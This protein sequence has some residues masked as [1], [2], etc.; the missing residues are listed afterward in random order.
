MEAFVPT[1]ALAIATTYGTAS[2]GTAIATL[3]GAAHAPQMQELSAREEKI[4]FIVSGVNT[5][6]NILAHSHKLFLLRSVFGVYDSHISETCGGIRLMSDQNEITHFSE[7]QVRLPEGYLDRTVNVFTCRDTQ[8]SSFNIARD[9]LDQGEN[10]TAY[11]DRQLALMQKHLKGWKQS[12]RS[13]V[14]L[15]DN[16]L[17]G[18]SVH[19]TFLREGKR[20]WQK[21]AVFNTQGAHILV[22][23]MSS[24]EKLTERDSSLFDDLLRSFRPHA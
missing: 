4:E 12:E 9:T 7:G 2:T 19:A 5:P 15:G 17:L 3:S 21:Q 22:F 16:L 11:T 13:A 10:L 8:G 1:A 24:A 23:T 18:E 20:I 14:M 6:S